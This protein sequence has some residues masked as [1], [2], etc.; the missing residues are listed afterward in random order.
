MTRNA[1]GLLRVAEAKG[2]LGNWAEAQE[3]LS[4][5]GHW[6][7]FQKEIEQLSNRVSRGLAE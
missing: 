3:E 5:M 1:K 2:L 4:N 6:E 7:G